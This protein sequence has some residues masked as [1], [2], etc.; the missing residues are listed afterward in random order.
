MMESVESEMEAMIF[1]RHEENKN[2]FDKKVV[3]AVSNENL[4][5]TLKTNK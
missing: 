5:M 2:L 1:E 4:D 3:N